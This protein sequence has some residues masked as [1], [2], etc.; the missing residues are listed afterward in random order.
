MNV[1]RYCGV[2]AFVGNVELTNNGA[3][4]STATV[5]LISKVCS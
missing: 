2:K 5:D 1:R 3:T 4:N